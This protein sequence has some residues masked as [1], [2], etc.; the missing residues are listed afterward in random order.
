[1]KKILNSKFWIL[2]SSR[3]G[4]SLIEIL[5]AL[6][7]GTLLIV[8]ATTVIVP[9]LRTNAQADKVQVASALGKELLETVRAFSEGDWHNVSNLATSSANKYFLIG[10][11]S[12]FV[13]A[14]GTEGIV[15]DGLTATSSL[16]GYWKLDESTGTTAFDFSGS[17]N[18]ST[19][20]N[21]PT[22]LSG[23]NCKVG[24]CLS[25]NGVNTKVTPSNAVNLSSSFSFAHWIRTSTT[26]GQVYTIG[27]AGGGNGYRF[28]IS[29]GRI[30]FLIGDSVSYTET[31]CGT[32]TVNDNQWH[33]IV[34][35]YKRT[36]PF[37]FTCYIDGN[38]A[39]T[40]S[41][42]S[43][44]SAMQTSTPSFG[45]PPCCTPFPGQLDDIRIYNR[46]LSAAE[47]K[48]IYNAVIYSRYFYLDDVGRD[49]SGAIQA[50]GGTND[51]STKKFTVVYGWSGGAT[52][53]FSTYLTR[54]RNNAFDQTDWSG[55]PGQ[56]GPATTTNN[57]FSTSTQIDY[58]TSTGSIYIQF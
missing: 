45:T 20:I 55:G 25:F 38:L 19:L 22:R 52:S 14:T 4:Q 41:L 24:G 26:T 17:N 53:S 37:L 51:P 1:M 27:N 31:Y 2:Y 12:P 30:G 28:G 5:I 48:S 40:T 56:D 7:V 13:V 54:Y 49:T 29:S 15:A 46:E 9:A 16:V 50:S 8:G 34:G 57:K 3:G 23:T 47:I 11:Y 35:V 42:P 39:A 44:Y 58:T 10:T 43:A 18:T 21:G 6:T 32:Q 36:S 33:H